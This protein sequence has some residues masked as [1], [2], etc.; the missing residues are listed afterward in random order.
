[1]TFTQ[2]SGTTKQDIWVQPLSGE[3][4]PFPFMQTSFNEKAARFSPDGH[5]IAYD[6]DES[7]RYEIYLA[8]FPAG[9][10]KWQ[11]SN[12]GGS[13]A[14]WSKNGME[15]YYLAPDNTI[16]SATIA[17][18]SGAVKIGL[19]NA[20][21]KAHPRNFDYGIY[22][23]TRDGRFLISSAP[24]ESNAPLTLISNWPTLVKK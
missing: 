9:G 3:Q 2:S 8:P 14:L 4:K 13:Q 15:L 17:S 6:S 11:V 22:D 20:L 21:F 19:P 7:G 16:M 23:V 1:M 24:D 18:A 12:A 10:R 5:W